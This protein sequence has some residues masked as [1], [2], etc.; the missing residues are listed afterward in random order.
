MGYSRVKHH[1][2]IIT[3]FFRGVKG[4][5]GFLLYFCCT[6]CGNIRYLGR[7]MPEMML[8]VCKIAGKGS[9]CRHKRANLA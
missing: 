6:S 1:V 3:A 8:F 7:K 5:F 9:F 4:F 2:T